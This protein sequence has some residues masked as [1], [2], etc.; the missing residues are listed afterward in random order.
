M[1]TVV[2]SD[3]TKYFKNSIHFNK[4]DLNENNLD[5]KFRNKGRK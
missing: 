2:Y 3:G 5:M 4:N 1:V